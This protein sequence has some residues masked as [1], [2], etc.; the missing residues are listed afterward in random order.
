MDYRASIGGGID[1][2]PS[3]GAA[4][5]ALPKN[6]PELQK[7]RQAIALHSR[8]RKH[9]GFFSSKPWD[10]SFTADKNS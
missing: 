5:C 7:R 3:W 6:K 9:P 2:L 8:L 4:C 1:W 10:F